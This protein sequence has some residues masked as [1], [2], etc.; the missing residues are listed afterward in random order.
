MPN[1]TNDERKFPWLN[2]TI[3][4][5]ISFSILWL[6]Q[7]YLAFFMSLLVPLISLFILII[8]L[9]VEYLEKSNVPKWYYKLLLLLIILPIL[10]GLLFSGLNHF[11]F[12]WQTIDF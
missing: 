12:T 8:S 3:L 5:V 11:E 7:D 1:S 9:I 4:I 6:I 10:T 2:F